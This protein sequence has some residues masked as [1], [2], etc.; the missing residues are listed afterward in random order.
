MGEKGEE[1]IEEK[2]IEKDL[3]P[4]QRAELRLKCLEPFVRVASQ[5]NL[6]NDLIYREAA[7][8]FK[9]ITTGQ[10][11]VK[12]TAETAKPAGD[13]EKNDPP[14]KPDNPVHLTQK[15]DPDPPLEDN[16]K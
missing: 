4:Y 12:I 2:S 14:L 10:T 5:L 13:V 16:R 3:T 11:P 9:F 15:D 8:T 7:K 1:K 6:G